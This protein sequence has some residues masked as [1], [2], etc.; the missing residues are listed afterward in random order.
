MDNLLVINKVISIAVWV[1]FWAT[2]YTVRIIRKNEFQA[3]F[4]GVKKMLSATVEMFGFFAVLHI[5][6]WQNNLS[7]LNSVTA[8]WLFAWQLLGYAL[9]LSG[10]VLTMW[11]A[12]SLQNSFISPKFSAF[13]Y[14][15]NMMY[16]GVLLIAFGSSVIFL[17]L[18]SLT[19]A[20]VLI[21]LIMYRIKIEDEANANI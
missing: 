2:M 14:L 20:I 3:A 18:V 8:G 15:R 6:L 13:R 12:W 7:M 16:A 10:F 1:I 19:M 5:T 9:L 4:V 17:N 11:V 21:P